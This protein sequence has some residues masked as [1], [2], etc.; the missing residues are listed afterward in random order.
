[1]NILHYL[2]L[3]C[4]ACFCIVGKAQN[5]TSVG[6]GNWT[7]AANWNNTSGWGSSTPQS[8]QSSGTTNVNNTLVFVGN[9]SAG[10]ATIN[11]NSSGTMN[12]IGDF[13][14]GGGGTVN[15]YGTLDISGSA[16]LNS[17]L[18]IYPGG[19]VI[20]D[21]NLTVVSSNNLIVGTSVAPPAYADLVVKG[22]VISQTSGDIT[23]NRNGRVAI[24]GDVTGTGG[25]TL[26]TINNGGQVY[27][28]GDLSFTGG[29]SHVYNNNTSSPY[30]FY[31]NG[32]AT[33][34]GG[35]SS[36]T[37][38]RGNKNDLQNTNP[39][40]FNWIASQENSPLPVELLEFKIDDKNNN[41]LLWS[42]ASQLNFSHFEVEHSANGETWSKIG[43]VEGA[44]N[45]NEYLAYS[46]LNQNP[47]NG[48]N[49]YR[50]RMVDLD[51]SFEYSPIIKSFSNQGLSL[52]VYPNPV[53]DHTITLSYNFEVTSSDDL[54]LLDFSGNMVWQGVAT[55][56]TGKI[57]LPQTI[58]PGTY[59]LQFTSADKNFATT[60]RLVIK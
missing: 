41:V 29:G 60:K 39:D 40:F 11:I 10:S 56:F 18:R 59:F 20:I 6:N 31:V 30:G 17:S 7:T 42:T 47:F 28:D 58:M 45:T 38:N 48:N 1:M 53:I 54:S 5:Y 19:K 32:T 43:E 13:A 33:S 35:G 34:S 44:G 27:V 24:Y 15:V 16:T 46:F 50:L 36:V 26:F 9:Y 51:E 55:N 3:A 21:G 4:S 12:V 23:V 49:Y 57:E 52:Q 25:G 37:S 8:G 14:I 2:F 22:N